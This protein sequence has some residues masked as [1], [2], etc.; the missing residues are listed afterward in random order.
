MVSHP[1][2]FWLI[3]LLWS[4]MT[5]SGKTIFEHISCYWM[6][7]SRA[8]NFSSFYSHTTTKQR[9]ANKNLKNKAL[10][11]DHNVPIA[12]FAKKMDEHRRSLVF[13]CKKRAPWQVMSWREP[14]MEW[15]NCMQ[16]CLGILLQVW[17]GMGIF[18]SSLAL[19][20]TK[21]PNLSPLSFYVPEEWWKRYCN[22]C[23]FMRNEWRYGFQGKSLLKYR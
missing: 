14:E 9:T 16:G 4:L 2:T 10:V 7:H 19:L 12:N 3:S 13:C 1:V 11:F 5:S 22:G 8:R 18:N 21:W 23:C 20:R 15:K 17:N 6:K